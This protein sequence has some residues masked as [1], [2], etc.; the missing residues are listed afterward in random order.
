MLFLR[1]IFRRKDF[2]TKDSFLVSFLWP[3]SLQANGQIPIG[4]DFELMYELPSAN[5]S[6]PGSP[7]PRVSVTPRIGIIVVIWLALIGG[8]AAYRFLRPPESEA[9]KAAQTATVQV[10]PA[11]WS[12]HVVNLDTETLNAE[13]NLRHAEE[14]I[15]RTMALTDNFTEARHLHAALASLEATHQSLVRSRHEIDIL[16]VLLKGENT[17]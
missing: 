2:E 4:K 10:V 15:R 9:A 11:S 14:E 7:P 8:Y 5:F 17:K 3:D 13:P 16:E 12:E 6:S 1:R